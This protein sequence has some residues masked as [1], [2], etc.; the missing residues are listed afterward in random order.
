MLDFNDPAF[1]TLLIVAIVTL[2][3]K[4]ASIWRAARNNQ[5]VWFGMFFIVNSFGILELT[6]LF[7]FSKPKDRD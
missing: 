1:R 7:Y 4:I 6:Y 5:M 2:P 3:L